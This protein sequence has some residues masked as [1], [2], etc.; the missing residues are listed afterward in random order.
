MARSAAAARQVAPGEVVVRREDLEAVLSA[1][2][3]VQAALEDVE[4]DLA[5][6]DSEAGVRSALSHLVA[7]AAPVA[8]VWIT[9]VGDA[10]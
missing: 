10:P 1:V 9:P 8:G 7:E 6:D 3:G 2:Y 4:A 5:D